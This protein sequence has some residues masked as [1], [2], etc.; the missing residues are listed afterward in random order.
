MAKQNKNQRNGKPNGKPEATRK[1]K[2]RDRGDRL[3]GRQNNLDAPFNDV[4]RLNRRNSSKNERRAE[5]SVDAGV[6][7][8]RGNPVQF[9]TKF[10]RFVTDA[11]TIPFAQPVGAPNPMAVHINQTP[12]T[13]TF[14][15]PGVCAL[16]FTPTIGV[17]RDFTSPINRS[18]IRFYTYMRSNQKASATYDHQDITMMEVALDSCY[19]FHALM[20]KLYGIINNFT[21]VNEYYSRATVLACGG[22][23][24]DIRANLEN[25]RSYI[26]AYA[27]SL[28]QYALP[29][30]IEMFNRH[31]WMV[32][33]M[34]TDSTSTHAQTYMFVPDG[35][36]LY[37]NT[38]ETGS[39]CTLLAYTGAHTF[40]Q[41]KSIGD[42]LLNAVSGDEDFAIISGDI[43]NFYGGNTYKLPYVAENYTV[44]PVYDQT[45][46][47]QIENA[48]VI[49]LDSTSLVISQNPTVNAGAIIFNPKPS[50]TPASG[51]V[52]DQ[53]FL[54]FHHDSPTPEEVIEGTRLTVVTQYDAV[55]TVNT[56]TA[57]G[58]EIVT[59]L[60]IYG[61]NANGNIGVVTTITEN[62][63]SVSASSSTAYMQTLL[64]AKEI[65]HLAQFDWAPQYTLW[66]A[67][68]S[69]GDYQFMGSTW[70]ID[71][72][73]MIPDMYLNNIH[74]GCLLSLFSATPN[75]EG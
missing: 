70:D 27:Y 65:M 5:E 58:T 29:G 68:Q 21:P 60:K 59:S 44:L 17:S 28:G 48:S 42:Q 45:V 2:Y 62:G 14:Y 55:N 64:I 36:W 52:I 18:S 38:V 3:Q 41:L 26:N 22:D 47:S 34:Y 39:Q 4:D 75:N 50:A 10:D 8:S 67:K 35:F 43:Y 63:K 19:M 49:Q 7:I 56:I 24:D 74:L 15:V 11:A 1:P 71:N 61:R 31:R 69:G 40:A 6:K 13:D 72:F 16:T 20:T 53:N 73:T 30:G 57:C 9:Y 25:F 12:T 51:V 54:N 32:E 37:D 66:A 46:L 23:F 33:G